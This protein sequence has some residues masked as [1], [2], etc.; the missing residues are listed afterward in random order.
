MK[1]QG[2]EIV[3]AVKYCF[4]CIKVLRCYYKNE[5]MKQFPVKKAAS[6]YFH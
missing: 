3:T 2:G 1:L 5:Y 6:K 4:L